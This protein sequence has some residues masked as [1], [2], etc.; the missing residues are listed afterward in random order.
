MR[1]GRSYFIL[2]VEN[3]ALA[4]P[5]DIA[6]RN[7]KSLADEWSLLEKN[8]KI[9]A[10]SLMRRQWKHVQNYMYQSLACVH[11]AS[12][13]YHI[14]AVFFLFLMLF[15]FIVFFTPPMIKKLFDQ[16]VYFQ[17]KYLFPR[18]RCFLIVRRKNQRNLG[19]QCP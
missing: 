4:C 17:P 14:L 19:L 12:L 11:D 6:R 10:C 9:P 2:N 16:K 3:I 5:E 8:C 18:L 1:Q 13:F 15:M 7:C